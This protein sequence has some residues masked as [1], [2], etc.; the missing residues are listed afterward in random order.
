ME[1]AT[2]CNYDPW[3]IWL[4]IGLVAV[5]AGIV[6]V[7]TWLHWDRRYKL[8]LREQAS[9]ERARARQVQ[10][11]KL[12]EETYRSVTMGDLQRET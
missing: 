10:N 12:R 11:I 9:D 1:Q 4:L 3:A 5:T 7:A 8:L 6:F 2:Q